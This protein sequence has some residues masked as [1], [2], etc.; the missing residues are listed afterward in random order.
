MSG[1]VNKAALSFRE[2][3]AIKILL[4]IVRM[5]NPTGYEHQIETLAKDILGDEK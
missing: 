5:L 2:K 3:A 4:F 1:S